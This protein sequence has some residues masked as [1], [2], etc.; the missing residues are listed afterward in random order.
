MNKIALAAVLGCS[1]TTLFAQSGIDSDDF[2]AATLHP[3]WRILDPVGDS[4]VGLQGFGTM[5]AQLRVDVSDDVTHDL[6]ANAADA[7]RVLQPSADTDFRVE[8]KFDAGVSSRFQFNG[9][10]AQQTDDDLVRVEF[11]ARNDATYLFAARVQGSSAQAFYDEPID[12]GARFLR[13]E[14][15]GDDWTVSYSVDGSAYTVGTQ[16]THAITVNEVGLHAG[17]NGSPVPAHT[18]VVDYFVNLDEPLVGPEDPIGGLEAP[19]A[20]AGTNVAAHPGDLV[21]LDG[22]NSSDDTTAVV[23]LVPSWT[24]VDRPV[25]STAML[26]GSDTLTPSFTVDALGEYV[27]E[28]V[29]VDA[30]GLPSAPS[31]VIVAS[32]NQAPVADAGGDDVVAVDETVVLDGLGSSDADD[33][34]LSYDWTL[35]S[36]PAGS[37]AILVGGTT[38]TPSLTPDVAGDYLVQLVVADAFSLSDPA[39]VTVTATAGMDSPSQILRDLAADLRF[40]P[41]SK[42]SRRHTKFLLRA[43]IRL[44]AWKIDRGHEWT[45]RYMLGWLLRRVDGCAERG[46]PDSPWSCFFRTSDWIVDCDLQLEVYGVLQNVRSLL[47]D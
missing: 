22:S 43:K 36:Q 32:T 3:R 7:P 30:D 42:F 9:I 10:V 45:A 31:Q 29:V 2:S 41:R 4:T 19:I 11:L 26:S 25:G 47:N 27:V 12:A 23:D 35:V 17:N 24:I 33:D 21:V 46:S 44:I 18:A 6:W 34:D 5:D 16:F 39:L 15:N 37:A 1:A 28:L 8:A 14:R 38:A 20:S 40:E 13:L